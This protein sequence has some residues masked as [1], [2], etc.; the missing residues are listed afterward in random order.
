[1][2][3]KPKFIRNK[4]RKAR[5][6]ANF[7]AVDVAQLANAE[8]VADRKWNYAQNVLNLLARGTKVRNDIRGMQA[9]QQKFGF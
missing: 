1:M 2:S 9:F 8:R 6:E 5:A 7:D 3:N 4:E